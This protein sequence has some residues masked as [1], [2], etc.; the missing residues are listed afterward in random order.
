VLL[1]V[2]FECAALDYLE[3]VGELPKIIERLGGKSKVPFGVPTMRNLVPS[4]T[5]IAKAK[6]MTG[7][8]LKVEKALR[9]DAAAPFSLSEL[10][11]FVHQTGDLPSARDIWQFW[12]RTEPLFRLMLEE[13]AEHEPAK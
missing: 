3:R 5:R 6:L 7:D 10:H 9:Y 4:L 1:R 11:A 13:P 12:V 2:F 8:A